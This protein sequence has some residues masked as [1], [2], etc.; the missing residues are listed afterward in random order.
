[1]IAGRFLSRAFPPFEHVLVVESGS[2]AILE[3]FLPKLYERSPSI[4]LDLVTCFAGAPNAFR[5]AQGEVFSV[6]DYPDAPSREKLFS[7]LSSR[8]YLVTGIICSA[9][10]IMTKWKWALAWKVKA[11]VLIINENADFFWFDRGNWRAIVHFV[12]F[13][14]DL[15]GGDAVRTLLRLAVFPLS[16]AYLMIY[17]GFVHAR[18]ALRFG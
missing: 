7:Q 2:R 8:G 3:T 12:L 14:A 10:P 15:T 9:E 4:R 16:L 11:K 1:M 13:R 5:P 17:A 6:L 18:R